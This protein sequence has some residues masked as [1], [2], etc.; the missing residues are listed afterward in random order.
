ME[1]TEG[2]WKRQETPFFNQ[3]K[4]LFE[5]KYRNMILNFRTLSSD[6]YYS[7]VEEMSY[8]SFC[9]Q[10]FFYFFI[11]FLFIYF[12]FLN[13][14]SLLYPTQGPTIMSSFLYFY[15]RL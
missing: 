5:K 4:I 9:S 2:T 1:G 7:G 11:E 15:F 3:F 14:F 8:S 13:I 6:M 10:G 12:F